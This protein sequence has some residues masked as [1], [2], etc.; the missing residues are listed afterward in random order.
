MK[1]EY[2][3]P[4][5]KDD[6]NNQDCPS[7]WDWRDADDIVNFARNHNMDVRGHTLVWHFQL[8][9]WVKSTNANRED[10]LFNHINTVVG[11]P[12]FNGIVAVWDVVN[13]AVNDD[14]IMRTS[15]QSVNPSIW[16]DINH[17][18]LNDPY[19]YICL[20]FNWAHNADPSARL[21]YNDYNDYNWS[22]DDIPQSNMQKKA[23][24]IYAMV[25]YLMN[26]DIPIHGDGLQLHIRLDY[27]PQLEAIK[28]DMDR[29]AALG[30]AVH[31]TEMDVAIYLNGAEPT[32]QQLQNQATLYRDVLQVCLDNPNCKVF[33]MWGFTDKVSWIPDWAPPVY[34]GYGAPLIYDYNYEPKTAYQY[35]RDTL[36]II[37]SDADG[38]PD[39][40]D[41]CSST[42]NGPDLGTCSSASDKPGITC[43]S[44][45][46]CATGCSAHGE[47]IKDQRDSDGDGLGDA[48]DNCPINCNTQQLD[49]D[50][51]SM[52]DVCDQAPGCGGCGQA[53]CEQQC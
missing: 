22:P 37:D 1:F 17:D 41:N 29:Y 49:A 33:G 4:C 21:F 24:K 3:H 31:I 19:E 52:G 25:R 32:E 43:N 11:H 26:H 10:I 34:Q 14:G 42:A 7:E 12:N 48:C 16:W 23:D 38:I 45:I 40:E 30:L 27:P 2:I 20:A 8:P 50:G 36:Q 47:C 6:P 18:P 28:Y 51:D 5:E 15:T 44:D 35:L 53:Q 46:D 9:Q 39:A 13:E